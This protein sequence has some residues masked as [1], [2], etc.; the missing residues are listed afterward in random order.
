MQIV[1]ICTPLPMNTPGATAAQSGGTARVSELRRADGQG[2]DTPGG[3]ITGNPVVPSS[4]Q[5]I[6]QGGPMPMAGDT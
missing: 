1:P 5:K 4:W 6:P 3:P 2:H